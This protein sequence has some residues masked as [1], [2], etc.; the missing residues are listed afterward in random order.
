VGYRQ[1]QSE[2]ARARFDVQGGGALHAGTE[3]MPAVCSA[4][5]PQDVL[6]A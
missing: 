2:A 3:V 4:A 1:G 6:R 5:G